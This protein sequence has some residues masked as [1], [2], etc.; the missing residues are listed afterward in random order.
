MSTP[1]IV[2]Q[3]AGFP[4]GAEWWRFPMFPLMLRAGGR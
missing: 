4:V 2:P 1:L 3:A